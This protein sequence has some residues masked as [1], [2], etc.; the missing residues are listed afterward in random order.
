MRACVRGGAWAQTDRRQGVDGVNAVV[1]RDPL[2]PERSVIGDRD[3]ARPEHGRVHHPEA[4]QVHPEPI[5]AR[6]EHEN[7][8]RRRRRR[9]EVGK[10]AG[11]DCWHNIRATSE[12]RDAAETG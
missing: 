11:G 10:V 5:R 7:R 4:A 6:V 8:R 2:E 1:L 9:G 3:G 12:A